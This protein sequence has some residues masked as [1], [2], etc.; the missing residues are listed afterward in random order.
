MAGKQAKIPNGNQIRTAMAF[1]ETTRHPER[2]KAMFLLSFHAGLRACEMAGATWIMALDANGEIGDLLSLEN[3]IAKMGS[4]RTV[5][6]SQEL[7]AALV[8]LYATK[9]PPTPAAPMIYSERGRSMSAASVTQFFFH[10]FNELGFT[11]CSSHSGRRWFITMGARKIGSVG[12]S[13]RDIQ[14]MAGHSSLTTTSRY[15]ETDSHAAR[16]LVN[17]L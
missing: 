15:I 16:K 13:L 2:N 14:Y 5:P 12:G 10:L 9:P 1:I 17:L 3:R 6:L 7:R 4:G 11:G 8:E